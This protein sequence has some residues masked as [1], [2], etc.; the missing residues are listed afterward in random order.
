MYY[1]IFKQRQKV[2][3]FQNI[4]IIGSGKKGGVNIVNA[5]MMPNKMQERQEE[6]TEFLLDTRKL[7][8]ELRWKI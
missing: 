6:A 1:T 4:V 7:P 8:K 3:K 5:Q 2:Y